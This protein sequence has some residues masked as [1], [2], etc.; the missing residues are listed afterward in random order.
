MSGTGEKPTTH[1]QNK[2]KIPKQ[3]MEYRTA[4]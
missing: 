1:I 2:D 3:V 4:G